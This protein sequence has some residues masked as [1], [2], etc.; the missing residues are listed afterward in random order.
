M[1]RLA[2][3]MAGPSGRD[4]VLQ[5][6]LLGAWKTRSRF[7]PELG[8]ARAWLLAITANHAKKAAARTARSRSYQVVPRTTPTAP[9]VRL[10]LERAVIGLPE[11]QRLAVELFY[12]VGLPVD[13]VAAVMGCANGTVKSTLSAARQALEAA[14]GKEYS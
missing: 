1:R 14:L 9:E 7:D 12:F 4:D 13:D 11:R 5:E 3:R 2:E 6:A 8:D 10:D